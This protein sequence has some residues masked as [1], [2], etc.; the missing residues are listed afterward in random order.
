MSAAP[1]TPEVVALFVPCLASAFD[2]RA[3]ECAARLVEAVGVVP[4]VV[5][6]AQTCCGQAL[7]N[8]G[9]PADAR[10][11][12]A[13]MARVFDDADTVVT[14]SAS[15]AAHLVHHGPPALAAR[16]TV[17]ATFLVARGFDAAACTWPGRVAYHPSCHGRALPRDDAPALLARVRD[18]ELVPLP[19][20][21]QCCGFGGTFATTFPEVSVALG[22]DKLAAASEAAATTLVADDAGC[23]LH[24][25]GLRHAAVEVKHLS[26]ILAEGLH[27]VPRPP[28]R[29]LHA[30]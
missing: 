24:L 19:R 18:L 27:L 30:A 10:R 13:R 6:A 11:L 1:A 22:E 8:A 7:H 26:E 15:C 9:L 23:R 4:L 25:A 16:V 29:P 3:T 5:P 2:V 17:L 28:R 20:A 14:T 12:A 21:S